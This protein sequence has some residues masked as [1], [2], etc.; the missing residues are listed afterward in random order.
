VVIEPIGDNVI[1]KLKVE[2][3]YK[4][5]SGLVLYKSEKELAADRPDQAEVVAVGNGRVL[6]DGRVREIPVKPGDQILFTKYGGTNFEFNGEK[7]IVIGV[8]DI[9]CKYTE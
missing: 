7:L 5:T 6:H 4:T 3:E 2:T 9:I 1:V 8:D